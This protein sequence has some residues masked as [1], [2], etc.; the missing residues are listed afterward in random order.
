MKSY[1]K[2]P[3]QEPMVDKKIP[4]GLEGIADSGDGGNQIPSLCRDPI[5]N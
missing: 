4:T 3:F 5:R 2:L 1:G